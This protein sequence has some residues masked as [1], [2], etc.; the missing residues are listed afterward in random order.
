MRDGRNRFLLHSAAKPLH[1]LRALNFDRRHFST[2]N[3]VTTTPNENDEADE[4]L[5]NCHK[6][7]SSFVTCTTVTCSQ[8]ITPVATATKEI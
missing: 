6:I 5:I 8:A 7:K 4:T 1:L 3:E 2:Q